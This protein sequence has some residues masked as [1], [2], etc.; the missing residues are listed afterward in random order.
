MTLSV[1]EKFD[2][3]VKYVQGLPKDGPYQPGQEIKLKVRGHGLRDRSRSAKR[4]A[5]VLRILQ[6]RFVVF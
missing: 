4:L 6:A 3:A 1:Q 5:S 2:K